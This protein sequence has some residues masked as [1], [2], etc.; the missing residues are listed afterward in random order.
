MHSPPP[1]RIV[2]CWHMHQPFYRDAEDRHYH[3]PW[4]YLHGIKEYTDMA[5][6]LE[7]TPGARAV[8]NFVPSLLEQLDEYAQNIRAYLDGRAES[9]RDPLL[10]L[11]A[12]DP[13]YTTEQRGTILKACFRLQ[14]ERN[15]HRYPAYSR[16]W[17]WAEACREA[18]DS[19]HLSDAY[20]SDLL[21]WY[22]LGWLAE[23]M[24]E[25]D[26]TARRLFAKERGYSR[27]DRRDL[28]VSIG[29]L[30]A[31]VPARYR[32]LQQDGIVELSTT[33]YAHPILP[34]LLDFHSA[35]ETV[36][37]A[38][39]PAHNYPS[40]SERAKE[41]IR[42]AHDYHAR[43]FGQ[44]ARGCWPSEGAVSNESLGLLAD[45]GFSWCATGEGILHHSLACNIREQCPDALYRP[46]LAG[47]GERRLACFFRDDHL[48]DLIGFQ[49]KNWHTG[50][51]VANFMHELQSIRERTRH[52]PH[53]V[54]SIIMD[55]ENAWE[56]Y[57]ENGIPFLS[58][59]YA[60]LAESPDFQLTT[61]SEYLAECEDM[62]RLESMVAGSWVYGN[63]STWIGDSAKTR[64]W[65][66]LVEAK[67]V[68]D[69]KWEGL[70]EERR[71][72]ARAQLRICE[73]SDWF[74]WFGD[75]N[76]SDAVR[77]FDRLYRQHLRRLYA[78][79]GQRAPAELDAAI[80]QGGGNAEDGGT[81]RRGGM[82]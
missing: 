47:S 55:G 59:L 76:P 61:F 31:E 35:R 80:S 4:V 23:T 14:H 82:A 56:H 48:S 65:E 26:Y 9:M 52:L 38:L 53:P 77:D 18:P 16:L 3:L 37:D 15:L 8:V 66:L 50:D 10:D 78:L 46:W 25:V 39:L 20:F 63:L 62:P 33:P 44:P 42:L 67:R 6:V 29:A 41:H 28:L 43:I 19:R 1:L 5:V 64:A 12:T 81:M 73:G 34:L 7:R 40:G 36:P 24:R 17:R 70:D 58:Q 60:T 2:F 68:Y 54:V 74:W 49:Y 32:R 45:A 11:L 79:L 30:L 69:E 75:Y 71:E 22:H 72:A 13:P 21:I 57:H 51:A 27:E